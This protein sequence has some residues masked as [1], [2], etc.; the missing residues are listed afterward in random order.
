MLLTKE[1]SKANILEG[2]AKLTLANLHYDKANQKE[3]YKGKMFDYMLKKTGVK[4][5]WWY[6][7][8]NNCII[9]FFQKLNKQ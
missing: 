7:F 8:I 1:Y 4:V 5:S 3:I 6:L 2:D 9:Y